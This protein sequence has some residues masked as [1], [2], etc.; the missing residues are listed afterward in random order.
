M[1][2]DLRGLVE[3]LKRRRVL[4]VAGVYVVV[5]WASIEGAA[6]TFP[7]LGL[8]DWAPTLVLALCILGFPVAVGLAWAF[9]LTPEGVQ[10]TIPGVLP[11]PPGPR[12]GLAV[13][14]IVVVLIGVGGFAVWSR[15]DEPPR[16]LDPQLVAVFPFR[17]SADPSLGYLREGMVDLLATK[18]TGGVGPR[19]LDARTALIAWKEAAG[20]VDADL[21]TAEA[22]ELARRAGAGQLLLGSVVGAPGALTLNGILYDVDTGEERVRATDVRGEPEELAALVDR[23]AGELLALEEGID[24]DRL[25]GLTSRSFP[26]LKAYLEGRRLYRVGRWAAGAAKL[27]EA[28]VLDSTFTLAAMEYLEGANWGNLT[29]D[30][31]RVRE[32]R[33]MAI[34]HADR[35]SDRDRAYF[36]ATLGP[37]DGPEERLRL[38]ERVV[39]LAPEKP[40]AW[41]RIGIWHAHNGLL[42]DREGSL[43]AARS[44]LDR[45]LELDPTLAVAVEYRLRLA[46]HEGDLE[47]FE[48]VGRRF[49]RDAGEGEHVEYLRWLIA[50]GSAD[51]AALTRIRADMDSLS[52]SA[53]GFIWGAALTFALE[54][55]DAERAIEVLERRARTDEERENRDWRAVEVLGDQ[56]RY[57]EM[58]PLLDDGPPSA[59]PWLRAF[60]PGYR[61]LT[62]GG[63]TLGLG[64]SARTLEAILAQARASGLAPEEV[65]EASCFAAVVRIAEGNATA[66]EAHLPG[67]ATAR[68]EAEDTELRTQD[69]MCDAAVRAA[70]AD[71]RG[72]VEGAV[73]HALALDSLLIAHPGMGR[74]ARNF[75]QFQC[76]RVLA[77]NGRPAE[78]LAAIRRRELINPAYHLA[79]MLRLEGR[80]AAELGDR[81]GAVRAYSHYLALRTRPDPELLPEVEEVRR[82]LA[83][84][85]AE[86]GS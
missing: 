53:L 30:N 4:R 84:L 11:A 57:A 61:R 10:R 18:L 44:A 82:E 28:V 79:P 60:L 68:G 43:D 70:A 64:R 45:A 34:R 26:A 1:L 38:L 36:D 12:R 39:R 41:Y 23:L 59:R 42:M 50:A 8:P 31:A 78:A 76:A 21:Q 62:W 67:L 63:D 2:V 32:I 86:R 83:E 74:L 37:A 47:T 66:A 46:V 69:A 24:S 54:P 80:L 33:Q 56:G 73:R 77:A 81:E 40:E 25:A 14:A 7:L 51:E 17:V 85:S 71:L 58:A 75:F 29:T 22:L 55:A 20:S 65:R 16:P 5:G 27:D 48:R 3:E 6:T 72:D 13:A 9:D 19:A 15:G 35:L 52:L 49:L